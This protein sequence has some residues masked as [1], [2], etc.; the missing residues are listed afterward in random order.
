MSAALRVGEMFAGYGG[1]G[2]GLAM[3]T[4]VPGVTR[5]SGPPT[6]R[7]FGEPKPRRPRWPSGAAARSRP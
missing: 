2:M 6:T 5:T 1:L 4:G 3:V 7:R